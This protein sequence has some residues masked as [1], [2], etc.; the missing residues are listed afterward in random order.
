MNQESH[1]FNVK[2]DYKTLKYYCNLICILF[3]SP[4]LSLLPDSHGELEN[5]R[6]L[7]SVVFFLFFCINT[8]SLLVYLCQWFW[9]LLLPL[10]ASCV[11]HDQNQGPDLEHLISP[12]PL[13]QAPGCSSARKKRRRRKRAP[14]W[15]Y[16][17]WGSEYKI[18]CS[19]LTVND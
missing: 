12:R 17:V 4:G 8:F 1:I 15:L 3:L 2:L 18:H 19:K 7:F 14:W 16:R 11:Q 13:R 5:T 9:L 6:F 10:Q